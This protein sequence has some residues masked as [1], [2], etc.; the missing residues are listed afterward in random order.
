MAIFVMIRKV[1]NQDTRM[2]RLLIST[3]PYVLYYT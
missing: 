3:D 1:N 2:V